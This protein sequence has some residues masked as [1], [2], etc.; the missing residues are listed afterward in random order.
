MI[1]LWLN[2]NAIL[3]IMEIK[4]YLYR[5][6]FIT[7]IYNQTSVKYYFCNTFKLLCKFTYRISGYKLIK[8]ISQSL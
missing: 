6:D 5:I 4:F 2:N 7:L 3:F 8:S 1:H